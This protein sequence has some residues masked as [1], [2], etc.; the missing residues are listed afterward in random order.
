MKRM[1][2]VLAVAAAA[3]ATSIR[4]EQLPAV[5]PTDWRISIR[6]YGT[7]DAPG[8]DSCRISIYT[9]G[10]APPRISVVKPVYDD[11]GKMSVDSPH[12]DA[13]LDQSQCDAVYAA[14][15]ATILG[16]QT[17]TVPRSYI[18]DGESVEITV[19]SDDKRITVGFDHNSSEKSKE[20]KELI[21]VI[22]KDHPEAFK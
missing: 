14:A 16:H 3:S 17:F 11:S 4:A 1:L 5:P 10:K 13:K 15:R 7:T 18:Q 20:F 2:I 19:S 6:F 8:H 12:F 21:D 22:K 9:N